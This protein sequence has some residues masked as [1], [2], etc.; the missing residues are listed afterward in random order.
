VYIS[1]DTTR[2]AVA[3]A[4]LAAGAHIV[5]DVSAGTE[6]PELLE[7]VAQSGAGVVLM[8]RVSP[9]QTDKYSH[10]HA[11]PPAFSDVVRQVRDWLLE[12]AQAAQRAGVGRACIALD[13]G[14]GF[15]KNVEQN[16]QLVAALHVL[17]REGYPV[18]VGASRKSFIGAATGVQ[19]PSERV[20][21]SIAMGLAAATQGAAVLRVHDVGEH[22]R[23]LKVWSKTHQAR[24]SGGRGERHAPDGLGH[25]KP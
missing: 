4:A 6:D 10:Q 14:L 18:V 12:R 24:G 16:F 2:A 9:P 13:P 17:V 20:A 25:T 3:R 1:I 21:G 8:H 19:K 11:H 7:A 23:A 5:N 15:G 22:A